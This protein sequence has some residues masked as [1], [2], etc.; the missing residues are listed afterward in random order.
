MAARLAPQLTLNP[1]AVV[2]DFP[3]E[4]ADYIAA[5]G[6][7]RSVAAPDPASALLQALDNATIRAL[8]CGGKWSVVDAAFEAVLNAPGSTWTRETLAYRQRQLHFK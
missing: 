8:N 1:T 6:R 2:I 3:T 7:D 4:W 5:K